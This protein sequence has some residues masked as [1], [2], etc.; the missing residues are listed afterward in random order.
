MKKENL[1][2]ILNKKA[3]VKKIGKGTYA[4]VYKISINGAQPTCLKSFPAHKNT[5]N[6]PYHGRNIETQL[7][8]FLNK[9]SNDFVKMHFGKV[10]DNIRR[11]GFIVTQFLDD[12][13]QPQIEPNIDESYKITYFDTHRNNYIQGKIID[14]GGTSIEKI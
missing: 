2:K 8:L 5:R 9:H 1:S 7:G 12:N 11:D 6:N 13:I 10:C 3:T 4:Q 14:Y